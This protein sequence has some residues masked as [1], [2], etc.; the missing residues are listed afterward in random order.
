MDNE[1]RLDAQ[2]VLMLSLMKLG[3]A[4]K[5]PKSEFID[6]L[7][8]IEKGFVETKDYPKLKEDINK[9]MTEVKEV[10]KLE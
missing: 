8:Y 9:L 7:D 6:K 10:F 4:L 5:D 3:I 2:I 1:Q